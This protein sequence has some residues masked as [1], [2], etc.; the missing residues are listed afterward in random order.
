MKNFLIVLI[1]IMN[2]TSQGQN[3][4][5]KAIIAII[6]Y[7]STQTWMF[8]DRKQAEINEK[9]FETIEK[10]L[11]EC[12]D[13]YNPEQEKEFNAINSKHPEYKLRK[14]NFVIELKKYKRQ[15]VVVT[16]KKG[17]KEVWINCF[18]G[19]S[20]NWKKELVIVN[21]GGNCYFNLVIN[22]TTGKFHD[23]LINGDA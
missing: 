3:K 14:D 10:I 23:L 13:K 21:D 12:I 18:C 19:E 11:K 15:Y 7:D 1:F 22:L 20:K 4:V 6:P 8:K 17:E 5:D 16:N 9:D 2:L